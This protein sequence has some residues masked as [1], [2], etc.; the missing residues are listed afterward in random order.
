MHYINLCFTYLLTSSFTPET[1]QLVL[2]TDMRSLSKAPLMSEKTPRAYSLACKAGSIHQQVGVRHFQ[3]IYPLGK[4]VAAGVYLGMTDKSPPH[5][6]LSVSFSSPLSWK[7]VR[8]IYQNALATACRF[9]RFENI[10][11]PGGS[12]YF[13]Y[14]Y[15]SNKCCANVCQECTAA[16]AVVFCPYEQVHILYR[17][18][19]VHSCA[20]SLSCE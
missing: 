7:K 13:R 2:Q 9:P 17:L 19:L 18:H 14:I 10:I 15:Q 4:H 20:G 5:R 1:Q 3:W 6:Y 11:Y 16:A 12:P 8:L